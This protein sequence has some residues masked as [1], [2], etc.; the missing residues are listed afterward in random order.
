M[1]RPHR[2]TLISSVAAGLA[3]VVAASALAGCSAASSAGNTEHVSWRDAA[4]HAGKVVTVC[5]PVKSTGAD[6]NDRFFNLGAPYPEEP[7]FT[8]VVW[9]NPDSVRDIDA[10]SESYRACVTGEVSIYRGVPEIELEN[11]H[12]IELTRN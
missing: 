9:D 2:A 7:R 1:S 12:E 10:E 8:I 4:D 5:G 3:Y 11:G 6:G